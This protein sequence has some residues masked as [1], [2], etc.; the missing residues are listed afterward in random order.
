MKKH[1]SECTQPIERNDT[2]DNIKRQFGSIAFAARK[3]GIAKATIYK[4]IR[5]D[6]VPPHA[7]NRIEAC[8][9]SADDFTPILK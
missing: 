6:G 8:G 5:L 1:I 7:R 2:Y 3:L 4:Y 9:Y